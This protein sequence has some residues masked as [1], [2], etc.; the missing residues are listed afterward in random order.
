MVSTFG[1]FFASLAPL[2]A[3][4]RY[5]AGIEIDIAPAQRL[6]LTPAR[7]GHGRDDDE[8]ADHRP[9]IVAGDQIIHG[10]EQAGVSSGTPMIVSRWLSPVSLRW[11][12]IGLRSRRPSPAHHVISA[13]R[14]RTDLRAMQ[15][16]EAGTLT[17]LKARRKEVLQPLISKHRG[18][19]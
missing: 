14:T 11:P 12:M 9:Q 16:D 18:R 17:S 2:R 4:Q 3:R 5:P 6:E 8:G 7:A 13:E 15:L 1:P 19:I 10:S